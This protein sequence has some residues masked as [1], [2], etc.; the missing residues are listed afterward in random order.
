VQQQNIKEDVRP[1]PHNG[2]AENL[3]SLH[4]LRQPSVV[5][6]AAQISRLNALMPKTRNDQQNEKQ[7]HRGCIGPDKA[8]RGQQTKFAGLLVVCN[9]RVQRRLPRSILHKGLYITQVA[10]GLKPPAT[11]PCLQPKF[12]GTKRPETAERSSIFY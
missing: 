12:A 4:Q 9:R 11:G 1:L 3:V 6:V 7:N 8:R 2:N 5:H 10:I